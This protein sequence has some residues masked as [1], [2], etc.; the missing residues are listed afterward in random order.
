MNIINDNEHVTQMCIT[1]SQT[2]CQP[3]GF[4]KHNAYLLLMEVVGF[5]SVFFKNK[6]VTEALV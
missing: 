1:Q 2:S 3:N 6:R 5:G 4:L